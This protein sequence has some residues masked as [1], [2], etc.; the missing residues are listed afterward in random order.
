MKRLTRDLA[1]GLMAAATLAFALST[2]AATPS[3][4]PAKPERPLV[5]GIL[6]F[7]SPI[8]LLK[9]FGPLRDY[10]AEQTGHPVILQTARDFPTFVRRTQQ[11]RYDIVL[12]APHMVLLALDS[13]HYRLQAAYAKPLAA[14]ILV[15]RNS[16]I[17]TL[18]QLQD[19]VVATPPPEAIITVIGRRM[20]ANAGLTGDRA[21]LYRN[22]L[23]HNAAYQAVIGGEANAAI[24]TVNVMHNVVGPGKPLRVLAKSRS[25]PGLGILTATDLPAALQHRIGETF[26]DM[27][28]TKAGRETLK[29][30]HYPGYRS[31]QASEFEPLRVYLG[32]CGLPYPGGEAPDCGD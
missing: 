24:I 4:R 13:G 16:A 31:A 27:N 1:R 19:K 5:M 11:R 9:R 7:L 32:S 14:V 6:P 15:P 17:R 23:S 30:I 22:Y 12:T 26:V 28:Q 18:A 20:L 10:L 29:R 21:P 8:A 25:F 3:A 2:A